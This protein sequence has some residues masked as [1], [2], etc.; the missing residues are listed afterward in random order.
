MHRLTIQELEPCI[1]RD[2]IDRV[3]KSAYRAEARLLSLK[4]FPP[5]LRS[6]EDL[7]LCGNRFLGALANDALC[8]AIELQKAKNAG[9]PMIIFSLAV[10]PNCFRHGIG[11]EL[12][13]SVLEEADE[14]N[15]VVTTGAKNEP[16]IR[17]YGQLGFV[18]SNRFKTPDGVD[19]VEL[20]SRT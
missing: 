4:V 20:T 11:K 1:W 8:G 17:L 10:T 12:V 2:E 6:R 7:V 9:E 15:L 13:K 5:L 3:F 18:L 14:T 19:M 16:A